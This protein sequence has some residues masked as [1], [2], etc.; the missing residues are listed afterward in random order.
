VGVGKFA[1]L[2][3]GATEARENFATNTIENLNLFVAAI[4]D[5]DVLFL[6]VRRK[7]NPPNGPPMIGEVAPS[8]DPD[9][10]LKVPVLSNTWIRSPCRSQT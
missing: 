3:A 6:A 5:V 2:M 10:F 8:L 1:D 9:I 4:G 7:S